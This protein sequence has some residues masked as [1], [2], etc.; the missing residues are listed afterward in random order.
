MALET[1]KNVISIKKLSLPNKTLN[2]L[3][4]VSVGLKVIVKI[5]AKYNVVYGQTCEFN[6]HHKKF[7]DYPKPRLCPAYCISHG[8]LT[9]ILFSWGN[10]Y[11]WC[12]WLMICTQKSCSTLDFK[13]EI[14]RKQIQRYGEQLITQS[15]FQGH[16]GFYKTLS[17]AMAILR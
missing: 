6:P 4:I 16:Q 12:F 10:Y 2:N 1:T 8:C 7:S 5:Y 14:F 17:K 3:Y 15:F 11:L 9:N 13:S